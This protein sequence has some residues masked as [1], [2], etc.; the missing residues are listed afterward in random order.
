MSNIY[1]SKTRQPL[2]GCDSWLAY[3]FD[4]YIAPNSVSA[5]HELRERTPRA[6]SHP[7]HSGLP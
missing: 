5:Y 1:L 6:A 3:W 4:R 2:A 7:D